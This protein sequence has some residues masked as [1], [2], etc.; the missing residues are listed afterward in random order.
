MSQTL[1]CLKNRREVA[2][3]S[4]PKS[5]AKDGIVN[6]SLFCEKCH[7]SFATKQG[8]DRHI[9][10]HQGKFQFWCDDCKKGFQNKNNYECHMAK[11][12]GRTFPCQYCP[13][14][15]SYEYRLKMHMSE[16]THLFKFGCTMCG[17]GFNSKS[18]RDKHEKNHAFPL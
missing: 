6:P 13:K 7:K 15:F 3:F 16:H 4:K 9:F 17:L 8:Y 2:I 14:R 18:L 11:H 10:S 5:Q 12:E 1:P